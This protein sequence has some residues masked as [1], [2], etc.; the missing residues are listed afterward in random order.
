[1]MISNRPSDLVEMHENYLD[2]REQFHV[3]QTG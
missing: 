1:M 2:L 3:A